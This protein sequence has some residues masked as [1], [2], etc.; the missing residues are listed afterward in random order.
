MLDL[1]D[2]PGFLRLFAFK[3][4]VVLDAFSRAP[5]AA[6]VFFQ[7]PTGRDVAKLLTRAARRFGPPRHSV[8]DQGV[9]FTSGPSRKALARLGVKHRYGAIG[10]TGSIAVIERFFRALKAL[11]GVRQRPPLLRRDLESSLA[12]ALLYY[13]WLRPHQ[14]LGGATPAELRLGSQHDRPAHPPPRG[15]PDLAVNVALDVEIRHLDAEGQLP[16]LVRKAA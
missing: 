14:G 1:T 2:I 10:K 6:R 8:S 3:L 13:L 7:E 15:V 4:A 5:L 16:Y 11:A 12:L 9:Q